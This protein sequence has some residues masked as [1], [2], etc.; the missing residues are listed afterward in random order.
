[1]FIKLKLFSEEKMKKSTREFIKE[2]RSAKEYSFFDL[3]HGYIYMRW[4][5]FYI[6]MGKGDHP[7]SKKFTP[8]ISWLGKLITVKAGR[9]VKE[10][11][12]SGFEDGYHGKVVPLE[13]AKQLVTVNQDIRLENLE[14]IIPYDRARDIILKNPDHIVVLDCPC[15]KGKADA[16]LPLD[17]CLIIGEPFASFVIEH[18]P[19]V[20]RWLSPQE[21]EQILKDEDERG[22]VHHAFFKDAVLGR[23]YAICNCCACCCEAMKGQQNGIPMLISS[24]YV[25]QVDEGLCAACG[26]CEL[27]CQFK[28]IQVNEHAHIDY[29]KCMGCGVCVNQ[30]AQGALKLLRDE[31][32]PQPLEIQKLMMDSIQGGSL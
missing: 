13:A 7:W 4:P 3:I 31:N 20:S 1:M 6:S 26:S 21:A 12:Q 22:H 2:A 8:L 5:Y 23:F 25:C 24:G 17:V 10:G 29:A 11:R 9:G 14:Q 18:H 27:V 19:K 28:A 15:R 16:C 30:C 32:L